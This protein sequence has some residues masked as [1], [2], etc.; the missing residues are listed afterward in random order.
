MMLFRKDILGSSGSTCL[1][2]FLPFVKLRKFKH[3]T[4]NDTFKFKTHNEISG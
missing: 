4:Q 3:L 2:V 1:K